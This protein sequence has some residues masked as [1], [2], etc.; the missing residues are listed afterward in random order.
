MWLSGLR[1]K[2]ILDAESS[3]QCQGGVGAETHRDRHEEAES[4][5]AEPVD[6]DQRAGTAD[7]EAQGVG[8]HGP[9][10]VAEALVAK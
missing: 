5:I 9:Q 6:G 3:D 7:Q 8:R 2:R 1:W 10:S 4:A